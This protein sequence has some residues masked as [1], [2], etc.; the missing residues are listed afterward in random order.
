MSAGGRRA[1][2][3]TRPSPLL[4]VPFLLGAAAAAAMW[5]G[6]VV[7]AVRMGQASRWLL[8]VTVT[9]AAVACLLL[10]FALLRR[11][12]AALHGGHA[13]RAGGRRKSQNTV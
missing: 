10:V 13:P 4:A 9:V 7:L 3:A 11:T 12:W 6:L 8:A 5:L 1:E 2:G